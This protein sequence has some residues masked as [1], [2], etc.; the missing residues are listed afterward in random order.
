MPI[1]PP[2]LIVPPFL[3]PGDTIGIVTPASPYLAGALQ[4]GL[5]LLRQWGFRVVLGRKG[6]HRKGYLAGT[7]L[8]RAR[9]LM[10]LFLDPDIKALICARGG[11]GCQRILDLLDYETIKKHPKLFMG[12]SDVTALLSA[13]HIKADL[14]GFHGP[15]VTTLPQLPLYV[16]KKVKSILM[17]HFQMEIPLDRKRVVRPGSARGRLVGGN[18]TL[19]SHLIGTPYEPFWDGAI[20]FIEDCGEAAYRL[21]RLFSHFRIA[22]VLARIS[23]IV[24]G[25]FI[26]P[27]NRGISFSFLKNLLKDLQVPIWGGLPFGHGRMNM[28]LPVGAPAF[29]DGDQ[30]LLR[31]DL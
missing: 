2:K 29:L 16:Q 17:G 5:F 24:L 15:M 28:P 11:Y 18:L 10:D 30:G 25:T 13:F 8:E 31:I 12:F 14:M 22:G 19:L 4:K 20:L 6:I 3:H 7:D 23:A 26:G 1:K 21:D 9:E 27:D